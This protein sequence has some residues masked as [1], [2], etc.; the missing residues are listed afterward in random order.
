M[1]YFDQ[2]WRMWWCMFDTVRVAKNIGME[3]YKKHNST[4]EIKEY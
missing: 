3:Q 4:K 2:T 1:R